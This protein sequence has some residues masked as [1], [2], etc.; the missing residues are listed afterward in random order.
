MTESVDLNKNRAVFLDRDG[1]LV[2]EIVRNNQ[3]FAALTLDEF[4]IYPEAAAQVQRL[5]EAGYLCIVFTNQPE[6]GRGLLPQETL[7]EMHRQLQAAMHLDD[8]YF[9][10][11]GRDGLC[12][13]RKPLP[14]MLRDAA[15]KWQVDLLTSFVIGDRW[16]DI[17]AGLS[18]GCFSIL[19]DR[20]YSECNRADARVESLAEAVDLILSQARRTENSTPA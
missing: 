16:R 9:C 12:Q 11:H 14:G 6:V 13:C 17:D 3:A 8:V 10:P 7:D 18:A 2:R 5:R 15:E 1:V 19:I 4:E 20:P